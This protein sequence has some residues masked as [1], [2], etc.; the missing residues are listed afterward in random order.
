[1]IRK[2][3]VYAIVL[4]LSCVWASNA[5]AQFVGMS[6]DAPVSYTATTATVSGVYMGVS[7]PIA[8]VPNIGVTRVAFTDEVKIAPNDD[9]T[10]DNKS[11]LIKNKI[12]ISTIN[13]FYN[14]PFPVV[15]MAVGFGAG[16]MHTASTM[17]IAALSVTD[18]SEALNIPVT[19][20]FIQVG[21]PFWNT[22][23]FHVGYHVLSTSSI[24]PKKNSKT[25]WASA[26]GGYTVADQDYSGALSTVGIQIA[27]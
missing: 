10:S 27:F 26:G 15:T 9:P 5:H 6:F 20:A 16:I 12:E 24:S 3:K 25:D 17:E 11:L 21:L 19:E 1:M 23:E 4:F 22:L 2:L 18:D 13:F 7:H 8:L 14:I